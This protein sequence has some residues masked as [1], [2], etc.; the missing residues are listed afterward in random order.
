MRIACLPVLICLLLATASQGDDAAKKEQEKLQGAWDVVLIETA[1]EKTGPAR[2]MK[3]IIKGD[4]ITQSIV[5]VAGAVREFSFELDPS[6][7]PKLIDIT[8]QD[9]SRKGEKREGI[10][11]VMGDD[12]KICMN[13]AQKDAPKQRPTEFETKSHPN[14]GMYVLRREKR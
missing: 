2:P 6:T 11:E 13:S 3:W 12:L 14:F 4:R 1:G 10:Y 9:S 5:N 8:Y 7:S